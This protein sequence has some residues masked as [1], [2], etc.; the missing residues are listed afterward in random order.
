MGTFRGSSSAVAAP[1]SAL[2]KE[3]EIK[4]SDSPSFTCDAD[5]SMVN[6]KKMVSSTI[7]A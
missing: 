3:Y 7:D 6:S 2:L 5:D 4:G 1:F